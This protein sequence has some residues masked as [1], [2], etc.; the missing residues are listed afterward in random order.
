MGLLSRLVAKSVDGVW[1]DAIMS[2]YT[3]LKWL[4]RFSRHRCHVSSS[5]RFGVG[6][7]RDESDDTGES[8]RLWSLPM[9]PV[10]ISTRSSGL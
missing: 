4:S 5:D 10:W 6:D 1:R 8:S 9:F 3:S 2:E 7:R